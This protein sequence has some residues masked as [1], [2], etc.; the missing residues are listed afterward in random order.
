M[1]ESLMLMALG[2][3]IATL[4]AI[5]AAQFVWRRAVTVTTRRLDENGSISARSADL[6]AMLQR[7]ERDAAPLHAEI[8]SL[9]AERRELAD[10]NNELAR[11]NNRLIAEAR[12]LTNEISKL[13]AELATRDTQAAAI[14]AE[15]ATLEQAIA[16]EARRHEEARTHLQNLSATAARLTAELRPAAA[17]ENPKSVTA[18]ALE[19]YPDDERDADART[20]A[21][22]KA[23][24]L[25][26]LDNTAEPEMAENRAEA[27]P[28]TNG[29]ALI[30]DLTL[31]ARIRA[32]E[33][34]VAPQ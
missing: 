19:P 28:E 30:G 9:R 32:L 10:A 12:S 5:I 21:E 14:G 29:D 31:A 33:A 17:P 11:D 7:Q 3:F 34:G 13:K 6:D 24:L 15:L 16:D 1:I 4:F 18:Q 8:E 23:S 22:V 2:F 20:L 27:G 26:E 25:E